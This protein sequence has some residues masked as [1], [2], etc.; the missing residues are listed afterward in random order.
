MALARAV[1]HG[2][3]GSA[4]GTD[5]PP[6]QLLQPG[7]PQPGFRRRL[8]RPRR[9]RHRRLRQSGR[10]GAAGAAGGVDRGPALGLFDALHRRRPRL[11]LADGLRPR[12]CFRAPHGGVQGGSLRSLVPLRGLPAEEVVARLLSAPAGE[13]RIAYAFLRSTPLLALRF[14]AWHDPDHR[15]RITEAQ[16]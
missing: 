3:G 11:R 8:R 6:V 4:G 16:Q 13:L 2:A 5:V 14:G 7:G 12:H 1:A 10:P 15:I 9:R